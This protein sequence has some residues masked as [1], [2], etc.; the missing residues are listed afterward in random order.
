MENFPVLGIAEVV[1]IVVF[2]TAL[3]GVG[4]VLP[5]VQYLRRRKH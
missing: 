1:F 4:F 5:V 3:F 2:F